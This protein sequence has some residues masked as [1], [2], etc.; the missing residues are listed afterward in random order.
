M[1]SQRIPRENSKCKAAL[2]LE[3]L[4][5]FRADCHCHSILSDGSETPKNLIFLTKKLGFQGL[6]ITDHDTVAAYE[7]AIPIAKEC[8]LLLLPGIE[9]SCHFENHSVHILGYAFDLQHP[10]L[11]AF[12]KRHE[13]R[14]RERNRAILQKLA[15]HGMTVLESDLAFAAHIVGRP[16]IAQ[17][18]IKKGY[19]HSIQEAFHQWIGEGKPCYAPGDRPTAEET[20]AII[21]E[22]GGLAVLAHPHLIQDDAFIERLLQLPFDGL[23][24]YYCRF[25]AP[26]NEKWLKIAEAKNLIPTGG[27]DFHGIVKPNISLGCSFT[28]AKSFTKLWEHY[29]RHT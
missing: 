1:L 21:H 18:M 10:S 7:E 13:E 22:A 20:I 26:E 12:C 19:V 29:A 28:P 8:D 23:E 14:R 24:A 25:P 3:N 2:H 11:L 9:L 16:H 15:H 27:S 4:A 5:D 17:A 6:S